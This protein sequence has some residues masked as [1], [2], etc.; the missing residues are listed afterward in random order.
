MRTRGL[1][2]R[3]MF[4]VTWV[5][6]LSVAAG[7]RAVC[8]EDLVAQ[9]TERSSPLDLLL[10]LRINKSDPSLPAQVSALSRKEDCRSER[11]IR[12]RS[13]AVDGVSYN[14]KP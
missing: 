5:S 1:R 6:P 7:D 9:A 14:I 3:R 11:K 2:R 10:L 4:E 13:T 12:R 8:P